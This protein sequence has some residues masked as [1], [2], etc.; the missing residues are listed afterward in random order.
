M[1]SWDLSSNICRLPYIIFA[2]GGIPYSLYQY[3]KNTTFSLDDGIILPVSFTLNLDCLADK[4]LQGMS[5]F[6]QDCTTIYS[7]RASLN[8]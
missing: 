1:A 3:R 8:G 4:E 7:A 5:I 6:Q 2:R